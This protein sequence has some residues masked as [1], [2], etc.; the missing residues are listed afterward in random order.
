MDKA[1]KEKHVDLTQ[2]KICNEVSSKILP[3]LQKLETQTIGVQAHPPGLKS[4]AASPATPNHCLCD[5]LSQ[6]CFPVYRSRRLGKE[7]KGTD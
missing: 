4:S 3:A 6:P 2:G 1:A 5:P 7:K